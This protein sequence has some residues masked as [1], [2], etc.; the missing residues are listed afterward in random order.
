MGFDKWISIVGEKTMHECYLPTT[1]EKMPAY[2]T[3][4]QKRHAGSV[5][6]CNCNKL[7]RWSGK[8]WEAL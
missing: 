8:K 4:L 7:Y 6:Q 2:G 1:L 5:W 3:S